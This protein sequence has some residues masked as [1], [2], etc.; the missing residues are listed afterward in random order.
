[1]RV[2]ALLIAAGRGERFGDAMPKQY[3][4]LAGKPVLRRTVE[5]FLQHPAID[6]VAVVGNPGHGELYRA[7]LAG[8][9]LADLIPGGSTRQD[10]V[11]LG[12]EHLA[13]SPPDVVLIHDAVRPL[14]SAAL[15]DRVLE[16]VRAH[17]AVLPALPVV[18]TLKRVEGGSVAGEQ[19]RQG[20]ARA[21][22]PQG[23]HFD[24]ILAAHRAAA[25][26]N[27]TDDTAVASAYGLPVVT[28]PGEERN[29]KITT[30]A[31]LDEAATRLQAGRR[32]ITGFGTDVHRLVQDRPLMLGG[33]H[34]PHAL[35][36]EGHSDADVGLHAITDALLGTISAGDIGQH[37]PPSDLQWRDA[38]SARFLVHARDLIVAAGG[39][40]E[41]VDLTLLCERPKISP[42]RDAIRHRIAG[43]LG[44]AVDQV[45]VKA[46]TTERL[47]FTGREEGILA[48]AVA[49]VAIETPS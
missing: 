11:R 2:T 43:L 17:P 39:R 40:I 46:T 4:P 8:L 30:P 38:D 45:S 9:G 31:D 13:G 44:L 18:D 37:F 23:F 48:Q 29:L 36:L 28:V 42:F 3:L 16:A 14:V 7:A 1:M 41:H 32:W 26:G 25:G 12:L 15:I 21:Q 5:R 19:S 22:T 20:L 35:G 24:R 49:T 47:G 33:I 27:L 10:S 6:D 34:I